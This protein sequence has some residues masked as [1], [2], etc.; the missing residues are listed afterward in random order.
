MKNTHEDRLG[1]FTKVAQFL[2]DNERVLVRHLPALAQT[3]QKLDIAVGQILD[4]TAETQIASA[5]Y[6][7]IKAAARLR[8]ENNLLRLGRT[9]SAYAVVNA[10]PDLTSNSNFSRSTV[11]KMRDNDLFIH[12]K[13]LAD[14][15]RP[16]IGNLNSFIYTST[17]FDEYETA[18]S[19]FFTVIQL[20]K[21]QIGNRALRNTEVVKLMSDTS[22]LLA[23]ELDILMSLIEYVDANLYAL[24]QTHRQIDHSGGRTAYDVIETTAAANSTTAVAMVEYDADL[25]I[26]VKNMGT[27][28]LLIGLSTNNIDLQGSPV[29]IAANETKTVLMADLATEGDFLLVKN[30][31]ARAVPLKITLKE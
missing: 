1:M 20:P 9:L 4:K 22:T 21:M 25:E 26:E 13:M 17:E 31:T 6:T 14:L 15:A 24:Y 12:S 7:A 2:T 16:L 5:G 30:A 11:E 28:L 27:E 19:A 3:K 8:L 18:Q 10:R 23:N 29:Q